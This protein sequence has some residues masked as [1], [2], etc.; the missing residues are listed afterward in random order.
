V[1][2]ALFVSIFRAHRRGY[3]INGGAKYPLSGRAVSAG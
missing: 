1:C 3:Y 2:T